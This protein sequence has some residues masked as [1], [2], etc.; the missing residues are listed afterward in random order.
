MKR[1]PPSF[2]QY[3]LEETKHQFFTFGR[4]NPPTI[5][6]GKLL[7]KLA[8]RASAYGQYRVFLSQSSDPK[9]NPL[10]YVKKVKH[11]RKMF[12][13][14]ARNIILNK[15]V[16]NV[17]DAATLLYNQGANGITMV[18]GSDR[19]T[20]FKTLLD[21]YNGK[22]GRHGFY[23]FKKI[24]VVSAGDRD[25]DADDVS[26]MSASKQRKAA[27]E[28]NFTAFSQGVPSSMSNKDTKRLFNDVRAGMGLKE[29]N[30][31]KNHI[32][33]ES[34]SETREDYVKGKLFQE[35]ERVRIKK[36]K[37]EGYVH[38]LGANYIIV[39]LDEGRIS[40]QW[41]DGVEAIREKKTD[42]WYSDKPE[43]GTDASTEKAKRL[44][45]GERQKT[46]SI[47]KAKRVLRN[48]VAKHARKF[49]K[50]S[51]QRDRKKDDKRGYTKHKNKM[52]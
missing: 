4:F 51:V 10:D 34:V 28:N 38:R 26:G 16:K 12:P 13:K 23:N 17:F 41:V 39:A 30:E 11:A 8:S 6:H 40:R 1:T 7:D 48:P 18:V 24:N 3:L 42:Q 5:G 45:P 37:K 27:A 32:E 21:K 25:P 9:K 33:F 31:F 46:E 14:H 19:V 43:W 44:T 2:K 15:N 29:T 36:S 50:A 22:E 49:N 47:A 20:E 52:E 35:G